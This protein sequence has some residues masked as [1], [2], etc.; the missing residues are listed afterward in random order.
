MRLCAV[1]ALHRLLAE[2]VGCMGVGATL[3][4][5]AQEGEEG[6]PAAPVLRI[7]IKNKD[8][9][10]VRCVLCHDSKPVHVKAKTSSLHEH[11]PTAQ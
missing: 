9:G 7:V 2:G 6:G 3:P 10:D 5:S 4:C 8:A 11:K 1:Q